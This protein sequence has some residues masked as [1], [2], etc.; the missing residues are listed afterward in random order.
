MHRCRWRRDCQ[1]GSRHCPWQGEK[2]EYGS[3]NDAKSP[4]GADEQVLQVVASVVLAQAAQAIPDLA[5][6]QHDLQT[7]G[8]FTRVAIT[9]N[10][11]TARVGGQIAAD[12][13]ASLGSQ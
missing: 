10:L 1:P 11:H 8:Q 4:L 3:G 2:L 6:G 13:A 9:Q 7:E 5:A 12:L